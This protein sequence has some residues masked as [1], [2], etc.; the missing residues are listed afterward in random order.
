M[1]ATFLLDESGAVTVDWTLLTAILAGLT[2]AMV[3]MLS[4]AAQ[5]PTTFLNSTLGTDIVGDHDSFD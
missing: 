3:T 5:Q 2:F 4:A 1:S